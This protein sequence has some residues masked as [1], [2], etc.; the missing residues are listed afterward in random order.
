MHI[1]FTDNI[2]Q[3][4]WVKWLRMQ[5]HCLLATLEVTGSNPGP[6]KIN[7][8]KNGKKQNSWLLKSPLICE[9]R[10]FELVKNHLFITVAF[11]GQIFHM[12]QLSKLD[13]L[14]NHFLSFLYH[15]KVWHEY[16]QDLQFVF[17]FVVLQIKHQYDDNNGKYSALLSFNKIKKKK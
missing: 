11:Q 5:E 9:K 4:F 8:T 3:W 15:M 2:F 7:S 12:N 14:I 10:M 16:P 6:C 13:N 17:L 1:Y